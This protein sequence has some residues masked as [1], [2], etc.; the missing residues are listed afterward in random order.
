MQ[1][2]SDLAV[3]AYCPRKL[4]YRRDDDRA[5]PPEV[6]QIRD[7][8]FRYEEL[9]DAGTDLTEEPIAVTPTQY[10][11]ALGGAKAR[12]DAWAE[13]ADPPKRR[14]LIEGKDCRGI[15]HKLLSVGPTVVS[16]GEPPPQGVWKPQSVRA[17]AAAK[18]LSY[19]RGETITT[20]FVEYPAVGVIRRIEVTG[21]RKAEYRRTLEAAEALDGDG[22]PPPRLDD[23]TKCESCAYRGDCGVRTRSLRSLL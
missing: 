22:E 4:Y 3:A 1:A 14:V 9:L 12:L 5:I 11:S 13:L 20:A 6:R 18:A 2:F 19:E 7:L 15:A 16:A 8:A 21:R 10:R 23:E 17:T